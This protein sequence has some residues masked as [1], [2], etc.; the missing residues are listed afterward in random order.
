MLYSA[1][2]YFHLFSLMVPR[3]LPV[4]QIALEQASQNLEHGCNRLGASLG[5]SL[6]IPAFSSPKSAFKDRLSFSTRDILRSSHL[7]TFI[8]I[9]SVMS[10]LPGL[11]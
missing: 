3:C 4:L 2:V 8:T 9:T 1:S 5:I 10:I 6:T 11:N 7:V